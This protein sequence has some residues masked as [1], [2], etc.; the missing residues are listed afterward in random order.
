MCNIE[1]ASLKS[2]WSV[3]NSGLMVYTVVL[4][5]VLN[6]RV[7]EGMTSNLSVHTFFA[8][9]PFLRSWFSM[10]LMEKEWSRIC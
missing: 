2:S 6:N 3:K 9:Y 10:R 5:K 7:N 1:R 4:K 8:K